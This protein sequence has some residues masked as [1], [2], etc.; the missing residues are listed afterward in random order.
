MKSKITDELKDL[1]SQTVTWGKLELE[2]MKLT[3]AEKLIILI[4]TL[5]V[6][7]IFVLFLLPIFIM[8]LFAL[9]GVFRMFMSAPLAYLSVAGVVMLILALV[10]VF[11]NVLVV[12][13]VSRF[14][15]KLFLDRKT[16]QDKK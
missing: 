16:S 2:Y 6:G 14:V 12:N 8:L 15:T 10:Y 7:A 13:V 5:I 11:R 9:A 4:S 1:F 3:A